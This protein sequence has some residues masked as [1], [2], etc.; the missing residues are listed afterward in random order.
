MHREEVLLE[1]IRVFGGAVMPRRHSVFAVASITLAVLTL[2][3]C[4]HAGTYYLI[5]NNLKLPY[6]K[7]VNSG[8]TGAAQQYGVNARLDG[9]DDY[10]AAAELDAFR[11][12]VAAKPA[13]ILISVAD[14]TTFREDIT[15][16]VQAGVP[17]I[18]VD[19]DA[20][21]SSRLFFIG[22]N[23]LAAGHI[24]GERLVDKL[25]G[26][27]NIVF[28]TIP[29][30]PNLDERLKGYKD[31]LADHAQMK[32]VDVFNVKGDPGAAFDQTKKYLGKTGA[33]K[34]DAFVALESSSG[35]AIADVLRDQHIT[36][37]LVIAM[38]VGPETLTHI[39]DGSI[40]S[41]VSQKPY[42]MGFVG[43]ALLD[44]IHHH[45]PEHF[46]N[47]Y[48]VDS[49]ARYPTFVDTGSALVTKDNVGVYQES[50]SKSQ[51]Q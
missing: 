33:D 45:K 1:D 13:G 4:Q 30:Q 51:A 42:T 39:E 11:K 10:N 27:G 22:T 24:G 49:F 2:T 29:G 34:I 20:P 19:S 15:N 38:D 36:D 6:W 31:I 3:S 37:R 16:A 32:I 41:T 18:T 21:T 23:N 44:Q 43:L 46:E 26:K 7:T 48:V 14:A 8:F 50:A 35:P 9:P 28:Y 25:K 5:S 17:V 47:N 40:D 12:A